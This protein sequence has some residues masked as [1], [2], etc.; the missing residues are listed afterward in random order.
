MFDY[1]ISV[2]KCQYFTINFYFSVFTPLLLQFTPEKTK[3]IT[4]YVELRK[5]E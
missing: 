5:V 2:F 1:T 3:I 4:L